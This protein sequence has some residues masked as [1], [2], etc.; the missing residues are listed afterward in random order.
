MKNKVP[1][2]ILGILIAAVLSISLYFPIPDNGETETHGMVCHEHEE[3]TAQKSWLKLENV[4]SYEDI[5]ENEKNNLSNDT[6]EGLKN[7]SSYWYTVTNYRNLSRNEKNHF[8]TAIDPGARL[9][10]SEVDRYI[11]TDSLILYEGSIYHCDIDRLLEG[12]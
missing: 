6:R 10:W 9:N 5:P 11:F 2:L 7:A 12:A 4:T 8:D 1:L 3:L